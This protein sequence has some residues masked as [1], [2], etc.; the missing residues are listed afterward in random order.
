MLFMI[1]YLAYPPF[2][3]KVVFTFSYV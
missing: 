2:I 3:C 1:L